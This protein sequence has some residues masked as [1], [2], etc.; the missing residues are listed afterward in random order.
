MRRFLLRRLLLLLPILWGV[1]TGVFLLIHLIPGDPVEIML[2][3]TAL[4]AAKD[5]LRARLRLDLPLLTQY[6]L[7]L[8]GLGRADLGASFVTQESVA[9]VILRTLPATVELA[10]A[11]LAVAILLALPLGMIAA[12]FADRPADRVSMGAALIGLSVPNFVLGPLL[13]LAFAIGTGFFPVSGREGA[14]AVVLPAITLGLALAGILSRMTRASLLEVLTREFVTAARARGLPERRV[15]LRHALRNAA[16]PILTVLGLQAGALLSGAI[17]TETIFSWPGLG[18]LTLQAIQSRDFPLVQ[19][20]V[21]TI[22]AIYVL[23]HLATDCLYAWADPR[24][25]Y[26][27]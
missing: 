19:G 24:I 2:G 16:I 13:I 10:A 14:G 23:V 7:F 9:G 6:G 3:E 15:L 26:D 22:A 11:G 5:A 4:P 27:A 20:C 25:R 21:L 17:I 8:T 1:A 12:V 18:R